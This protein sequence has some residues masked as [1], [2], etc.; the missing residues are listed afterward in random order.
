MK[1]SG[2]NLREVIFPVGGIGA[3]C[4]GISGSGRLAEWEIFNKAGKF[5]RNGISHF[6]IRA[7]KDGK[8]VD[9][10]IVNGPVEKDLSGEFVGRYEGYMR[11]FGWGPVRETMAGLP[12]FANCELDG[13]FPVAIYTFTDPDF[14]GKVTLTAWSSFIPG[15]SDQSS[16]PAAIFELGVENTS[17]VEYEYDFIGVLANITGNKEGENRVEKA[18]NLT[19]L[20]EFATDRSGEIAISTDAPDTAYQEYFRQDTGNANLEQ[21][22]RDMAQPEFVNHPRTVIRYNE[23]CGLLAAAK[24]LAPGG[25]DA[26]RFVISWYFPERSNTWRTEEWLETNM[27]KYGIRENKWRNYYAALCSSAAECAIKIFEKFDTLRKEVFRFRD[28]LHDC[29]IPQAAIDG[30]A[31]NLAVLIS[32][33]CLRLPD[34][35]FYGWEGV[36]PERGSCEGSCLHVWNYAQALSMLFP[37]LERSMQEATF[38]YNLDRNDGLQFRLRLPLGI[39]GDADEFRPCVDGTCGEVMKMFRNW[40]ISGDTAWMKKLYPVMKTILSYVWSD[41][42]PDRWDDQAQ[43][44]LTGRQH[45]TLDMELFGPSGWLQSHYL[46]ALKAAAIMAETVGDDEFAATCRKLFDHGRKFME[47]ELFNGEYY[48]QKIDL[49]DHEFL[50]KYLNFDWE[51]ELY[52]SEEAGE[53]KHQIGSGCIIDAHLG[54]W[55]TKLFG[56]G[57]ILDAQQVKSTL[58]AIVRYNF[59]E[60]IGKNINPYRNFALENESGTV[61]CTYPHGK[62]YQG[63]PYG[64]EC[65]T[66]FEWA[67]ASHLVCI[68][69]LEKAEMIINAIRDRYDGKKRNPW[70]EIECG[71]NYARSMAAYAM[72]QSYSGFSCDMTEKRIGFAPKISGDFSC[73]WSI[74]KVWGSYSRTADGQQITIGGGEVELE[75]FD[76]SSFNKQY[77]NGREFTGKVA[78]CT[79]DVLKFI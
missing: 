24:T 79:G 12:H 48:F 6:A 74:G 50:K 26:V 19:I 53:I 20:R 78:V 67:L 43:G 52:F 35:T 33:V 44:I 15:K 56:I 58:L 70:N 51:D 2:E 71:S 27:A 1:L 9:W 31:G 37:D 60:K 75:K 39:Q 77:L 30:A 47:T 4:I 46:G 73:F 65:M 5:L 57:E 23:P 18:G 11:G 29:T 21:Y 38:K 62:Q 36:G 45:H 10:R 22:I 40:K 59:F 66:G 34:G 8:V 72:L 63:I 3:G 7:K 69:E 32:P 64:E 41:K 76:L 16:M 49:K 13:R 25:C 28:M 42:N 68:G 55:Y 14:P 17:G 54:A 61:M